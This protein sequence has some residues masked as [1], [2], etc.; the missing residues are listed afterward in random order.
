MLA[1]H[2]SIISV[3]LKGFIRVVLLHPPVKHDVEED[4]SQY[5]ANDPA[6]WRTPSLARLERPIGKLDRC[7]RPTLAVQQ[8]MLLAGVVT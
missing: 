5:R 4:V 1:M 7:F 8:D 6:L 3:P 2:H